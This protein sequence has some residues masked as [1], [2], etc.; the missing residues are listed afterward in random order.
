MQ[1]NI[2]GKIK[3]LLLLVIDANDHPIN[4]P[5]LVEKL[6]ELNSLFSHFKRTKNPNSSTS[7]PTSLPKKEV[8][9]E[10]NL[11]E[12][13]ALSAGSLSSGTRKKLKKR[14][15]HK[16]MVKTLKNIKSLHSKRAWM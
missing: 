8:L 14:R 11:T 6:N 15:F 7:I 13:K 3:E 1:L 9:D 10:L 16:L 4:V 5:Q 2:I 12:K